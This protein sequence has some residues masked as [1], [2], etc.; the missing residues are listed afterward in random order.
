[1]D[2]PDFDN[3]TFLD[4]D[5]SQGPHGHYKL[6]AK[7]EPYRCKTMREWLTFTDGK[8]APANRIVKQ[9]QVG[10]YWVSTVFLMLDHSWGSGPPVLWET[11][12]FCDQKNHKLHQE[13]DR[14]SG[15]REQAEA[16]HGRVVARCR[17][18]VKQ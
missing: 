4:Q 3:D 7:G 17:E 9:E 8:G 1:M 15:G 13:M 16:M 5:I 6:D 14:C 2:L 10:K 12:I 11:M 18:L